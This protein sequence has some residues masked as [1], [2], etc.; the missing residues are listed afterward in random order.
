MTQTLLILLATLFHQI[1]VWIILVW[2][3]T[4]PSV[5]NSL[6]IIFKAVGSTTLVGVVVSFVLVRFR[7][8]RFDPATA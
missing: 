2:D 3:G 7:K 8:R 6:G 5:A 1:C 4:S